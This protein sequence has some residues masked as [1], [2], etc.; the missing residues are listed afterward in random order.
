MKR[1]FAVAAGGALLMTALAVPTMGFDGTPSSPAAQAASGQTPTRQPGTPPSTTSPAMPGTRQGSAPTAVPTTVP[2]T[3]PMTIPCIP[4]AEGT[5][6]SV[7]TPVV[8]IDDSPTPVPNAGRF[9]VAGGLTPTV[10]GTGTQNSATSN[11]SSGSAT[12]AAQPT[13]SSNTANTPAA[14]GAAPATTTPNTLLTG[15]V[16]A[17]GITGT[18]GPLLPCQAAPDSAAPTGTAAPATPAPSRAT[19]GATTPSAPSSGGVGAG[20]STPRH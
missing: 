1:K 4:A 6:A 19:G 15:T 18:A 13:P 12:S 9:R 14:A 10:G 2:T 3:T 7:S 17:P 20:G 8:A 5:D 16:P 11:L